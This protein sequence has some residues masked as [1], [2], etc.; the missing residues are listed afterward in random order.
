[1]IYRLVQRH[2][3]L[4]LISVQYEI[5]QLH[6]SG[7]QRPDSGDCDN[8]S[9]DPISVKPND[10]G[11]P[12]GEN[13][14]KSTAS[15]SKKQVFI[16]HAGVCIFSRFLNQIQDLFGV[17]GQIV[18]QW[19]C[20]L[21]LEAVNIEQSKYLDFHSL[22][23][24][25]GSTIR[26]PFS[27]RHLLD[28]LASEGNCTK[29][30]KLNADLFCD[31]KDFTFYYDPHSKRYTGIYKI[32]KGWCPSLGRADKVLHSD[33]IHSVRGDPLFIM[34]FDNFYDLRERYE[35]VVKALRIVIGA[36]KSERITLVLDRAIYKFAVFE[37]T[38]DDPSLEI[39]TWEKDYK[40]CNELWETHT[41]EHFCLKKYKNSSRGIREY[42]FRYIDTDW[43]KNRR[44]RRILVHAINPNNK[45]VEVSILTTDWKREASEIIRLIFE[46]WIQENDFKYLD[47]HYGINQITSYDTTDYSQLKE[48]LHDK[49]IISGDYKSLQYDKRSLEKKLKDIIYKKH[50]R[51]EKIQLAQKKLRDFDGCLNTKNQSKE[52]TVKIRKK[53]RSLKANLA[54]WE[55]MNYDNTIEEHTKN[56]ENIKKKLE[57]Q[58]GNVSKVDTLIQE[59]Y[60]CLNVRK[61]RFMDALRIFARN[62]FYILFRPFRDKYDNFRDDHD[63]FRNL[64]HADGICKETDDTTEIMLYPSAHLEPKM[65]KIIQDILHDLTLQMPMTIDNSGK[66]L[67][68]SLF[69]SETLEVANV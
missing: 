4:S 65:R 37:K 46:R 41:V 22:T 55:K 23:Y 52:E 6:E 44:V 28:D 15:M 69:E 51:D 43:G 29:I 24:L 3:D 31:N 21:Y 62:T 9:C 5:E 67:I 63:Y 20:M 66:K 26:R 34:H 53:H 30:F 68:L 1:M 33:F 58:K 14:H 10:S 11:T 57:E 47:V 7:S 59:K 60:Q 35:D 2:F 61:K 12:D 49:E 64:T 54:R 27:Q 19:L 32:L 17:Y 42:T 45:M 39:I 50:C 13:N 18:K 56:L 40:P 38:V 16:R 8:K 36:E 48:I 25:L